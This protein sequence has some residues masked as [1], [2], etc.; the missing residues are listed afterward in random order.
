M[1]G[2][3]MEPGV[4][5]NN[6]RSGL[7]YAVTDDGLELPVIDITHPDFALQ[8]TDPEI[9]KLL[10]RHLKDVKNQERSPAFFRNLFI[11]IMQRRS[12]LMRGI[13]NSAGTYLSA[14]ST[15]IMKLGPDN[16]SKSYATNID[17]MIAG[18]LPVLSMRLRFQDIVRLMA[19]GL[20]QGLKANGTAALH[21]LNIGGGPAI[22]SLN[23]LI[24]IHKEHPRL[25]VDRRIFIHI[26]D[27]DDTGPN[28]GARALTSLMAENGPL[29]GLDIQF[30]HVK[31]DWSD[32]TV[33]SE[34][35]KGFKGQETLV[36]AS[37][38]GALF[39]YGSDD[40]IVANLRT[41][42]KVR[43][44]GVLIVGTV[45]RADDIG[46][47]LN[48]VSRAAINLRGLQ[49]FT[50]LVERGGWK[51]KIVIDRPMS[52]DILLEKA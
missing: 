33:L 50:K 39:E 11:G 46:L 20:V 7:C 29:H 23:T 5:D 22:D 18:S 17:R 43:P 37:S 27:L 41:L 49:A 13:A 38:E 3:A 21:L 42:H 24:V 40:E 8:P 34:L 48:R 45:T 30:D 28:F 51:I 35:V 52:H 25:L 26:L 9:D 16:L 47:L 10:Q 2:A 12:F 14:M 1:S 19:D 36:A 32:P 4:P 6:K 31:Y 44:A 15:Y